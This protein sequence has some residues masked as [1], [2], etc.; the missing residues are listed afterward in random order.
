MASLRS[1]GRPGSTCKSPCRANF[2]PTAGSHAGWP[3]HWPRPALSSD[4]CVVLVQRPASKSLLLLRHC[5]SE[6]PNHHRFTAT[7][8]RVSHAC[9]LRPAATTRHRCWIRL[10]CFGRSRPPAAVA[11]LFMADQA[12]PDPA[13]HLLLGRPV[14]LGRRP[15]T[16]CLQTALS[17]GLTGDSLL[18]RLS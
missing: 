5:G 16:V 11:I 17:C 14:C 13:S 6:S 3:T 4:A 9:A 7:P 10:H 18:S 15:T 12:S 8:C 2:L 1:P